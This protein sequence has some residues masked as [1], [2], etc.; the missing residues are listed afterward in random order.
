MLAVFT[1]FCL[2]R[3][4][5]VAYTENRL[6]VSRPKGGKFFNLLSEIKVRLFKFHPA[7][8]RQGFLFE[9]LLTLEGLH[10]LVQSTAKVREIFNGK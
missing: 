4:R 10:G 6:S 3:D 5:K 8:D 9:L 7:I 1:N 2:I